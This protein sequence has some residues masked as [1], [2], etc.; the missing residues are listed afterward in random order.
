M[1]PVTVSIAAPQPRCAFL[2]VLGN[3]EA[4][5]DHFLLDWQ[6]SGPRRGVGARARMRV[7]KAAPHGGL[8]LAVIASEPPRLTSE[9][10]VGAGG[11]RRARRTH[12][13]EELPQ[14]ATRISFELAWLD[15]PLKE[16]LAA[17]LTRAVVRRNNQRSLC[18]LVEQPGR[19][20]SS[21][22]GIK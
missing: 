14:G 3:H 10:S 11:R 4:F 8:D 15:A 5:T 17:P 19:R 12:R 20:Q 21:E 2:D 6:L 22:G 13:L 18:R 9:E 7:K 1:R 16:R